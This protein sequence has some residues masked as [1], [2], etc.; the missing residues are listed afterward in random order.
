M[1]LSL[2]AYRNIVKNVRSRA[3]IATLCRVS[4]GFQYVAERALYNT[5]YMHDVG[6][7]MALCSTL[8]QQP[9]VSCLVEALTISLSVTS[10][11][12]D[13]DEEVEKA[14]EK[15]EEEEESEELALA[16]AMSLGSQLESDPGPTSSTGDPS[17]AGP[18]AGDL[19]AEY[20]PSISRALQ[21]T[22]ALKHLNI[23]V[24]GPFD[25]SNTW[26]FEGCTF[27]LQGFHCDL[28]W[29]DHLVNFL[30]TQTNLHDLYLIDF[31]ESQESAT[32]TSTVVPPSIPIHNT[33]TNTNTSM[34]D[35][36]QF[37]P[38]LSKL[39]CTF[40]EAALSLVP[41][42]PVTHLKTCFS[43]TD[44]TEK[45]AELYLL[46]SKIRRSTRRL[47]SLD[48]ADSSY[49]EAFSMEMLRTVVATAATSAELRYLGTVVLPI[50]GQQSRLKAVLLIVEFLAMFFSVLFVTY[51]AFS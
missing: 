38:N 6:T 28:D 1:E 16:L 25:T 49:T 29:N 33:P 24:N 11:E 51:S 15:D 5:L 46:F 20:W 32:A 12:E 21:K 41:N 2:E 10:G 8:A 17:T 40:S 34:I 9:R 26:I 43:R 48:I 22:V 13:S 36:T 42:R 19:P 31:N 23:L 7:T 35:T 14:E 47:R 3:D 27:H 45:R 18:V 30:R 4:K 37:L 50:G 44:M 39:E